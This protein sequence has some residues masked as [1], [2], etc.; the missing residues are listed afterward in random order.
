MLLQRERS[1]LTRNETTM[2]VRDRLSDATKRSPV[3]LL[4]FSDGWEVLEANEAMLHMLEA[5]SIAELQGLNAEDLIDPEFRDDF[6]QQRSKR[7]RGEASTYECVL[8]GRRG[9]RR[10][11]IVTGMPIMHDGNLAG[12]IITCVDVS[13]LRQAEEALQQQQQERAHLSRLS[14]L[15]AMVAGISHE[16]NQP[17]H[18]IANFAAASLN[19]LEAGKPEATEQ[20]RQWLQK[21]AQQAF[22]ASEIVKRFRQFSSPAAHITEATVG[23]LLGE[24]VELAQAEL[25]RRNVKVEVNNEAADQRFAGDHI[26]IQQVLLNFLVN[27]AEALERNPEQERRIVVT[28]RMVEGNLLCEVLDN[29]LSGLP[30]VPGPQLFDSFYTTKSSGLGLGLAISR[31]IIESHGGRIWARPNAPQGAVFG[32]EIP[33]ATPQ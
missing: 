31:T 9:T 15:G 21:I 10:Q 22:R 12:T 27:A 29:G 24:A 2:K 6:Q 8:L 20:I 16:I 5:A 26:Q 28:A 1:A 32:F 23:E 13:L 30:D 3:G 18:A 17:L 14:A 25:R 33:P 7:Y 19:V 11:V 4:R